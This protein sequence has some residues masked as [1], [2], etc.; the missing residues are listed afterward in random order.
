MFLAKITCPC[1]VDLFI[2][3]LKPRVKDCVLQEW[4]SSVCD[5]SKLSYYSEYKTLLD[6]ERYLTVVPQI[7]LVNVW[8]DLG[9]AR[10]TW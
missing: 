2:T 1:D 6:V 8:H 4:H 9:V 10:I 7:N 3:R 5:A